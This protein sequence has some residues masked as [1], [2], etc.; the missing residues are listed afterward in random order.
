MLMGLDTDPVQGER[1]WTCTSKIT[2]FNALVAIMPTNISMAKELKPKWR[3]R[4][5]CK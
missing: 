3:G 5:L 4:T 2:C 1:S